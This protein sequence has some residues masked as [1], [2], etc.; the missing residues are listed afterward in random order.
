M[1]NSAPSARVAPKSAL[2]QRR[3]GPSVEERGEEILRTATR[4][5]GERGYN[6]TRLND[7]AV[8][9]GVTRAA[10]YYYFARGKLEILE[11][12]CTS[13]MDRAE[14]V[15]AD[16]LRRPDIVDAF[17]TF[18]REYAAHITSGST[19]ISGVS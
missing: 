8:E 15:T 16:A 14:R 18:I 5:F 12:V 7:I 6:G 1:S 2:G 3:G 4:L 19:P 11:Q 10:L 9:L 17:T 13:G